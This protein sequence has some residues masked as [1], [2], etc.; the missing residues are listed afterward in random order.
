M[1]NLA[2]LF[3]L[4]PCGFGTIPCDICDLWG[5]ANSLLFFMVFTLAL[6]ILVLAILIGGFYWM[7]SAGN[8]ERIGKGKKI[9]TSSIFGIFIAFGGWLIVDTI[10]KTFANDGVFIGAW[11]RMPICPE[12][13]VTAPPVVKPPIGPPPTQSTCK[14][15]KDI[16]VPTKSGACA[17]GQICKVNT[18]LNDRLLV[19]NQS[20][21][22]DNK[23][24]FWQATEAWPPTISHQDP[25]H[26]NGT[27][28]D[29]NLVGINQGNIQQV[30]YFVKKANE[31]GLK[32]VY[33]V[34]DQKKADA[35]ITSGV[36]KDNVL[37]LKPNQITGEHFSIYLK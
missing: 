31:A 9:L 1:E 10:I 16:S 7:T 34:S 36:P 6:P 23:I 28:V 2:A 12:P 37:V 30:S 15:C 13:I 29:A 21:L 35:L 8:Q 27:C 5:L 22:K 25:C 33:E 32:A 18:V 19:L 3:G 24:N 14:D 11:N 17:G 4:V 20:V 26:Q